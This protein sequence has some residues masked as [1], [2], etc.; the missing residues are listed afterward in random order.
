ML[1]KLQPFTTCKMRR[2]ARSCVGFVKQLS[3]EAAAPADALCQQQ[4]PG[5]YHA[6]TC[7]YP[8][9][10]YGSSQH[11]YR[12]VQDFGSVRHA[13]SWLSRLVGRGS[14]Q[15]AATPLPDNQQH[16]TPSVDTGPPPQTIEPPAEP[17]IWP[18]PENASEPF[19][20]II[21]AITASEKAVL[22]AASA[23]LAFY[24]QP[25]AW[26]MQGLESLHNQGIAW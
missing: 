20:A 6:I 15:K 7:Q 24:Q 19:H 10:Q 5:V 18:L 4:G 13:S 11:N 2:A 1:R 14:D 22:A 26:V 12:L 8:W 3:C 16:S 9:S 17:Q 25:V 21:Q 23:D